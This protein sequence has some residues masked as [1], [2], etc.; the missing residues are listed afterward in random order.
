MTTLTDH[1]LVAKLVVS[2]PHGPITG[3]LI[4]FSGE[5][6]EAALL[7]ITW[8]NKGL[9]HIKKFCTVDLFI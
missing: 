7:T 5:N 2:R 3:E 1:C 9:S 6:Q 8:E 4:L